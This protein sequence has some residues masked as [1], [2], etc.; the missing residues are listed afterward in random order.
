M[1][2]GRL[3]EKGEKKRKKKNKIPTIVNVRKTPVTC[4][5]NHSQP[6][7]NGAGSV[8]R[9]MMTFVKHPVFNAMAMPVSDNRK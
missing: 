8:A 4:Q 5:L 7:P 3:W 2:M 6:H 1:I 9:T